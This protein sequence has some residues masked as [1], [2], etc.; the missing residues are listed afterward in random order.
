MVSLRSRPEILLE[1]DRGMVRN[2]HLPAFSALPN[3]KDPMYKDLP[4]T[5]QEWRTISTERN[6]LVNL[7][8]EYGRPVHEPNR[9][10]AWLKMT[11]TSDKKQTRKVDIEMDARS[12]G[13]RE[14]EAGVC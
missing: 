3:G 1:G 9:A 7:S 4:S 5:S 6:G 12:V 10:I 14:R 8:R 13:I 11:I 2:W